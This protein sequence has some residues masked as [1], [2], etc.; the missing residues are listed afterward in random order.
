MSSIETLDPGLFCIVPM[1]EKDYGMVAEIFEQ[2]IRG[3]NATYDLRAADWALWDDKHLKHSRLVVKL[4][5]TNVV[6]GWLAL[7]AV[8]S[9]AVFSG[10][11]ELSIYIHQDYLGRGLGDALMVQGIASSEDNGVWTLQSGIFPEN[12]GSVRL[13]EKHGFRMVGYRERLG[14]MES[15]EWRD[16][17]LLERRSTR[18]GV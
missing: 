3:G 10:V 1:E 16:I 2:G 9:R 12:V 15:G 7:S 4:I 13:H 17:V 18:V 8:S 14:Q 11:T 5:E 6:V